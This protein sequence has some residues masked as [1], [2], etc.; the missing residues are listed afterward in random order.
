MKQPSRA[1]RK[2]PSPLDQFSEVQTFVHE[3]NR[4]TSL[5]D[6]SG[7]LENCG[8]VFGFDYFALVHHVDLKF[9]Y[10]EIIRLHNYPDAWT[11]TLIERDYFSDDP[12]HAACQRSGVGFLW[13]DVDKIISLNSRHKE[14]LNAAAYAGMGGGFTVPAHV[15]GEYNGSCSFATRSGREFS[16][17]VIPATHYLG[18]FAFEAARR[19]V[20]SSMKKTPAEMAGTGKSPYLTQR[21]FDCVVLAAK[22]K[23]DWDIAQLL[24]ISPETVHQHIEDAKRRYHVATRMQLVVRTLFDSQLSFADILR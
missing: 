21:Q 10:P 8:R 12:I 6:L 24:G 18:S 16:S 20:H 9:D 3:V 5:N 22:G 11:S 23:S 1:R 17:K 4:T 14:I 7:L 15:P 19:I 13:S 2:R